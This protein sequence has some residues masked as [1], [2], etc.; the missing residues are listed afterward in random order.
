MFSSPRSNFVGVCSSFPVLTP[1]LFVGQFFV[2]L[3]IIFLDFIQFFVSDC[4][5]F[6]QFYD[7][8]EHSTKV[9]HEI[10]LALEIFI[11]SMFS[12]EAANLTASSLLSSP[13]QSANQNTAHS[14][15]T[16]KATQQRGFSYKG[17]WVPINS[18]PPS[19][20]SKPV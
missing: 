17:V 20:I 11:Q 7:L 6:C 3:V 2:N 8:Q 10:C 14:Q 5:S 18:I 1:F 16:E 12:K 15:G 9:F 13:Q 4:R 19:G